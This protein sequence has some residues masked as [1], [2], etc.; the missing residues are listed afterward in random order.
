MC[1]NAVLVAV[2]E[3]AN[4]KTKSLKLKIAIAR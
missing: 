2:L 3:E 1:G 4:Y